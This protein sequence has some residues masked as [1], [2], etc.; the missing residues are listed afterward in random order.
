MKWILGFFLSLFVAL[1]ATQ[2]YETAI[3]AT[4]LGVGWPNLFEWILIFSFPS[5]IFVSFYLL[6]K[7]NVDEEAR[8][9]AE[10]AELRQ[11]LDALNKKK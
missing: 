3:V 5:I 8:C 11:R 9:K 1:I 6:H 7:N 10:D 4:R 2:V